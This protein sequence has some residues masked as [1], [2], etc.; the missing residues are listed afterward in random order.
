MFLS[1][2]LFSLGL[3]LHWLCHVQSKNNLGLFYGAFQSLIAKHLM[4]MLQMGNGDT[5]DE[6]I[7]PMGS[8][9]RLVAK[10]VPEQY[11]LK[12]PVLGGK[13][14]T[15]DSSAAHCYCRCKE[16]RNT[17]VD[18]SDLYLIEKKVSPRASSAWLKKSNKRSSPNWYLIRD[19]FG[20]FIPA[21]NRQV[22]T[23]QWSG[24]FLGTVYI[25]VTVC[26]Q[27]RVLLRGVRFLPTTL[28]K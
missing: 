21:S 24:H 11:P 4:F 1:P 28:S 8:Q 16:W 12:W 27:H 19:Q 20:S 5:G 25:A 22:S 23:E 2:L 6:L 18:F 3:I 17:S 14:E 9:C 13:S 15:A 10:F 7:C 26:L